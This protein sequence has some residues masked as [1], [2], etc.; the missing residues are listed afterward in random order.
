MSK[1]VL[2]GQV[3]SAKMQKTVVVS[4]DV[5]KKHAMYGKAVRNTRRFKARDELGAIHGD[6]VLIEETRPYSKEVCWKVIE[7]VGKDRKG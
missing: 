4:L 1:K 6:T 3:V 2:K 7:I 5:P